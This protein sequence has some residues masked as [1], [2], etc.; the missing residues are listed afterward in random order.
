[1]RPIMSTRKVLS[2]PAP[3]PAPSG[4]RAALR[5]GVCAITATFA[6]AYGVSAGVALAL[7][8]LL[9]VLA[10]NPA[11]KRLKTFQGRLLGG[12]VCLMGAG[13][14]VISVVR[15]G[16][17]GFLLTAGLLAAVLLVGWR[18]GK[19]LDLDREESLLV[20]AGTAICGGSAI[21]SLTA[22]IRPKESATAF[23]LAVVFGL[24]AIALVALPP[25]GR[26]LGLSPVQFG[27]WAALGIHDT[28]SVVGATMAYGDG[29]LAIGTTVKLSRAL[30]IVPLTAWVAK[31]ERGAAGRRV[32][33]GPGVVRWSVPWF[34]PGFLV[35]SAL[36]TAMPMLEDA[37]EP[38]VAVAKRAFVLGLFLV[39]LS[40]DRET[41]RRFPPRLALFGVLL[42]AWSL[43]AA[44]LP[45][46]L[47]GGR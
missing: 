31:S 35:L 25:V 47:L 40:L 18:L 5:W 39:G 15:V 42:W 24:N 14:D 41:V 45:A 32:E 10:L 22:A 44:L 28:S 30:W 36:F 3:E 19:W 34:L 20:T 26:W 1:M 21:A 4:R 7:G 11:P 27:W 12:A 2:F 17:Q 38:V 33:G 13:L 8:L 43:L 16:T 29:A 37:R 23:A 46:W 6:V 9:G